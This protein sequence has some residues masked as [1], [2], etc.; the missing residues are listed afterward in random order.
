MRKCDCHLKKTDWPGAQSTPW[1]IPQ[2]INVYPRGEGKAIPL[3]MYMEI[4]RGLA[5]AVWGW[6]WVT[7]LRCSVLGSRRH[8]AAYRMAQMRRA[9]NT[10]GGQE[11]WLESAAHPDAGPLPTR[12]S[13]ILLFCMRDRSVFIGFRKCFHI[14]KLHDADRIWSDIVIQTGFLNMRRFD[15][16]LRSV[17]SRSHTCS[18]ERLHKR[19]TTLHNKM[20]KVIYHNQKSE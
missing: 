12:D 10:R 8:F 1:F 13:E 19:L 4:N 15:C 9:L 11:L 3:R 2:K 16:C 20:K 18:P 7:H 5:D 17:K 14:Y 6:W